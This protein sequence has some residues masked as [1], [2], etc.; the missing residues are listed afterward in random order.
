M[1]GRTGAS[2]WGGAE[3]L[4]ARHVGWVPAEG[5]AVQ[6]LDP[7]IRS[8]Q[9]GVVRWGEHNHLAFDGAHPGFRGRSQ[10]V[11]LARLLG[12]QPR[13]HCL[14]VVVRRQH[15]GVEVVGHGQHADQR[16][17]G[18][19]RV[20]PQPAGELGIGAATLQ[21]AVAADELHFVE[22]Q[23]PTAAPGGHEEPGQET[24]PLPGQLPAGYG[25]Q[26][27][28]ARAHLLGLSTQLG[29]AQRIA[30]PEPD[31]GIGEVTI[32]RRDLG[33]QAQRQREAL[34]DRSAP[35]TGPAQQLGVGR[36]ARVEPGGRLRHRLAGSGGQHGGRDGGAEHLH[37]VVQRRLLADHY[38]A[39]GKLLGT[40]QVD[41]MLEDVTLAGAESTPDQQVAGRRGGGAGMVEQLE[42]AVLYLGLPAPQGGDRIPA[43]HAGAQRLDGTPG[44]QP[45]S[46]RDRGHRTASSRVSSRTSAANGL[47][48]RRSRTSSTIRSCN[49]RYAGS[50][51]TSSVSSSGTTVTAAKTPRS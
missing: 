24:E 41:E 34:V 27:R 3:A 45:V 29:H 43:R 37:R 1:P 10:L 51:R 4:Q 40:G 38:P 28:S 48:R 7:R 16:R 33:Q 25:A 22:E 36:A 31:D 5:L 30:G 6:C 35:P 23:E 49:A 2:G 19:L 47:G 14:A 11:V 20:G 32:G 15:G 50:P 9:L 26:R 12:A 46:R 39:D 8:V 44:G 42:E 13:R 18:V 17:A 21:R